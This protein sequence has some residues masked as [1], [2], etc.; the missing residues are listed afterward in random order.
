MFLLYVHVPEKSSSSDPAIQ[1]QLIL[2]II[3]AHTWNLFAVTFLLGSCGST[4]GAPTNR[5]IKR[6]N[7]D[8]IHTNHLLLFVYLTSAIFHETYKGSQKLELLI[9]HKYVATNKNKYE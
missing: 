5:K 9:N 2:Y 1:Y 4:L 8:H 3:T 7:H 6:T